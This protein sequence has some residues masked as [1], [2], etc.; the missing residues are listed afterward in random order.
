MG[1]T[2]WVDRGSSGGIG[3]SGK[4]QLEYME[5]TGDSG[6]V[7]SLWVRI[8]GQTNNEMS[9]GKSVKGYLARTI[10]PMNYSLRN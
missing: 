5:L 6:T 8:K 1:M 10:T 7:E 9:L 4:E 2:H 3:R